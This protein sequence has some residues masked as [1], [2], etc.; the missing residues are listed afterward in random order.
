[1]LVFL[2]ITYIAYLHLLLQAVKGAQ[3]VGAE[4]SS[5][6]L[7]WLRTEEGQKRRERD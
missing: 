1:V 7:S 4:Y 6:H 5:C 3:K 2:F